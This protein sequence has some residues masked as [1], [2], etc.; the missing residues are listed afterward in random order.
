V[1]SAAFAPDDSIV[2]LLSS[3]YR[4]GHWAVPSGRRLADLA[5]PAHPTGPGQIAVTPDGT[6]LAPSQKNGEI[7]A[8]T[9]N[10]RARLPV[11]GFPGGA[12]SVSLSADGHLLAVTGLNSPPMLFRIGVGRL[13]HP[14]LVGYVAAD[15]SGTRLATGSNDP[16]V[17]IWDPRTSALIDTLPLT[18][19]GGPLGL[20]Y[21]KDGS[22]AAGRA[23]GSVEVFDPDGKPRLTRSP[24]S[25]TAGSRPA[26]RTG[27]SS[28]GN[29][30]RR[31]SSAR[32][33]ASPPRSPGPPG[34]PSRSSADGV[35]PQ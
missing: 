13:P 25:P 29:S 4:I 6:V 16:V 3:G 32:S 31:R 8:L 19:G 10:G 23:A 17:R 33:A 1:F 26:H 28:S 21:A 14:Q 18:G 20:D 27:S 24:S 30:T 11:D 7:V 22:L 2:G 34:A 5:D 15:P 35:P 9:L 12:I